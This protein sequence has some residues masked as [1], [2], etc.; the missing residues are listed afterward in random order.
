VPD[1][2]SSTIAAE[3]YAPTTAD[4]LRAVS[5]QA[6]ALTAYLLE[7]GIAAADLQTT[8]L[9]VHPQYG[10]YDESADKPAI[11]GYQASVAMSVRVRDL[12]MASTIVDGAALVVGDALRVYGM[13]WAIGDRNELLAEAR[14]D[15]VQRARDRAAQLAEVADLRLGDIAAVSEVTEVPVGYIE[16]GGDGA[17]GYPFYG[18]TQIVRVAVAVE[19]E[20]TPLAS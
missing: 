9:S 10:G 6:D 11:V 13:S 17:S 3:T 14:A 16:G 4:A 18:G 1:E 20:A 15:A 8:S 2:I 5:D 12:D 7:Q 19:F